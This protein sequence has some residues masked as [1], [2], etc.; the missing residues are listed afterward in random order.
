[1]L[2]PLYTASVFVLI[3]SLFFPS[4]ESLYSVAN[5]P[6]EL[7][8]GTVAVVRTHDVNMNIEAPDKA[9]ETISYAITILGKNGDDLGVFN[10]FY[11]KLQEI[12]DI[13]ITIYD[14]DG[15][16]TEKVKSSDIE[17]YSSLS[18]YSVF[19]DTRQK[20]YRPQ[21]NRY[22]YT[23]EYQYSRTYKGLLSYPTWQPLTSYNLAV[24][25]STFKLTTPSD[26][27][28]RFYESNIDNKGK[29][30]TDGNRTVY[31]WSLADYPSIEEEDH[32]PYLFEISPVVR[33]AP[34]VFKIEGYEGKMNS[35]QDYGKWAFQLIEGRDALPETTREKILQL[36]SGAEDEKD[37][38][39]RIY[40]Y[41]QTKTRYVSIQE[42]IGSW[43]PMTAEEVDMLGYGDCKALANYT[44]SLLKIAGIRSYYTKVRAGR[45]EVDINKDFVSNQS[46]HII[47]C[48]PLGSDTT[49]LE[50]TSQTLPFGYLGAFTCDRNVLIV[51]PDGGKIARSARYPV[52]VNTQINKVTIRFETTDYCKADISSTCSGLQY[53]NFSGLI[54]HP[55]DETKKW[56]TNNTGPQ[57]IDVINFN[58][59]TQG[60]E[61]PVISF[62]REIGIRNLASKTGKRLFLPLNFLNRTNYIPVRNSNRIN[63]IVIRNSYLDIDSATY[64][65][66]EGY[67]IEALP[68]NYSSQTIFGEYSIKCEA[69]GD[70]VLFTRRLK[71]NK[72]TYP[73]SSYAEFRQY[74]TDITNSDNAKLIL[75]ELQ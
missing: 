6:E 14:K 9:V 59:Q 68:S 34:T 62:F 41:M 58:I 57:D 55:Y 32:S 5:I 37:K 48:V 54:D 26:L 49:W 25:S 23:I 69:N 20:Y 75:V 19:E 39:R 51:S 1:M 50:C 11:D 24:Q 73:A 8:N 60:E 7:L 17:D 74:Y 33:T 27:E 35:W 52:E 64:I 13:K 38:A 15:K 66:P 45:N 30:Y 28:V 63:S 16:I 43:Q 40:K 36:I 65:L 42:G 31:E 70:S 4:A 21:I 2:P 3:I 12:S 71:M 44:M 56:I 10:E 53:E 72:G 61:Y 46:N 47:L 18:G 67:T 22:P 29:I